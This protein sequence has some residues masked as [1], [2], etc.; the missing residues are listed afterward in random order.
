MFI[1]HDYALRLAA[2]Y[3]FLDI[4]IYLT[5]QGADIHARVSQALILS[6][7]NGHLKVIKY[8]VKKG[9]DINDN[10]FILIN[11][12]KKG[13]LKIVKF[14]VGKG[15]KYY[16]KDFA[17]EASA[18]SGHFHI[19]KFL[20]DAIGDDI[21]I[22]TI[23]NALHYSIK[24]CHIDITK[25]LIGYSTDVETAYEYALQYSIKK[26]K[27]DVVKFLEEHLEAILYLR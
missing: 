23:K 1:Y 6:E 5:R 3:G 27:T 4:V 26:R 7:H 12:A 18:M 19:A 13:Y 2:S 14:L 11:S 24:K 10:E 15:I 17:L 25:L 21:D 8:L 9:I 22:D 20:L 16:N